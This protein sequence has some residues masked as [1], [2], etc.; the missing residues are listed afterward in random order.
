[1]SF[2]CG[3]GQWWWSAKQGD[4]FNARWCYLTQKIPPCLTMLWVMNIYMSCRKPRH[5]FSVYPS[6]RLLSSV[7]GGI[8]KIRT[9]CN[10]VDSWFSMKAE[11][12]WTLYQVIRVIS[13]ERARQLS[14]RVYQVFGCYFSC[15]RPQPA[16]KGIWRWAVHSRRWGPNK[17]TT[18]RCQL[19]YTRLQRRGRRWI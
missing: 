7:G 17:D 8:G 15:R 10:G 13:T 1:M 11:I 12:F 2:F 4:E 19:Q 9:H 18:W 14:L 6:V 3:S 16:I 5:G